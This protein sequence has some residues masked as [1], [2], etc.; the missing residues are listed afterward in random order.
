MT[1]KLLQKVSAR[2]KPSAKSMVQ[3]LETD[4][5]R[6]AVAAA[7]LL[8][9]VALVVLVLRYPGMAIATVLVVQV[10]L[11]ALMVV[12]VRGQSAQQRE[13]TRIVEEASA[14]SLADLVRTRQAILAAIEDTHTS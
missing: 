12:V 2:L 13:Q 10:V 3:R 9:V 1:T 6:F 8:V 4:K 5:T 14:R 7:A 11:L